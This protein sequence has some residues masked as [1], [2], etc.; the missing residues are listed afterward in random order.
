MQFYG[1]TDEEYEF[2]TIMLLQEKENQ[3]DDIVL[4]NYGLN[5]Y[6][7]RQLN[8]TIF[9]GV[10]IENKHDISIQP[11]TLEP[12]CKNIILDPRLPEEEYLEKAKSLRDQYEKEKNN[13]FPL[14]DKLDKNYLQEA[15]K[16]IKKFPKNFQ[17]K[18]DNLIKA[19]FLFDYVETRKKLI[20]QLNIS[21]CEKYE[22][23]KKELNNYDLS[24]MD[25]KI[26]LQNLDKQ[27]KEELLKYPKMDSKSEDSIFLEVA[28]ILGEKSGQ[29]K[30]LYNHIHKFIKKKLPISNI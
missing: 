21:T 28:S 7:I 17:K 14:I 20:D 18:Q 29:C 1:E 4:Q 23:N 6:E 11:S 12:I 3:I 16:T 15:T 26:E 22:N 10:N 2:R 13:Y 19:L 8:L 25:K 24:P 5:T 9:K 30:K 27:L